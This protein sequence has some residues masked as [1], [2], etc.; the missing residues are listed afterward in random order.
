MS[1]QRREWAVHNGQVRDSFVQQSTQISQLSDR[2]T[3]QATSISNL[4]GK[5]E[6]YHSELTV[7]DSNIS[8]EVATKVGEDEI[9]AK[10]NLSPETASI[11]ASKIELAADVVTFTK[12]SAG[13]DLT[14]ASSDSTGNTLTISG[15]YM[16]GTDDSGNIGYVVRPYGYEIY[17]YDTTN[18]VIATV[19]S[20]T[21]DIYKKGNGTSLWTSHS[22]I[23]GTIWSDALY[24]VGLGVRVPNSY[25]EVT[26]GETTVKY[27]LPPYTYTLA[28]GIDEDVYHYFRGNS[29]AF[30]LL[31]GATLTS[32][33]KD[34]SNDSKVL[35][36][37]SAETRLGVSG[38]TLN[39]KGSSI[40]AT[41][42]GDVSVSATGTIDIS[43]FS[44]TYGFK[45]NGGW[46]MYNNYNG[47]TA[48]IQ[49]DS[50]GNVQINIPSGKGVYLNG[51]LKW[52]A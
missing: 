19:R 15:S 28:Y 1:K 39:L 7:A 30:T 14:I 20:R 51:S 29:F 21:A 26:I 31:D 35:V 41:T 5:V 18:R 44:G 10:I 25:R 46:E 27:P 17:S 12:M 6:T 52:Q 47:S 8:A 32:F 45:V 37:D 16:Q 23:F 38:T 22:S 49:I 2:I 13:D 36:M 24:G 48:R 9:I 43:G 40:N 3:L 34:A 33:A 50:S 11:S 42:G 4:D